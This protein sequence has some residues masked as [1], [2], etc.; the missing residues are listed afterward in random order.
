MKNTVFAIAALLAGCASNTGVV[1]IGSGSYML[2]KQAATG[3]AGLGNLKGEAIAEAAAYCKG[4]GHGFSLISS[5]ESPPPYIFGN[6]PR[7][8]IIFSCN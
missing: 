2:A 7:A 3:I 8:E 4:S 5:S 6:Y 1:S